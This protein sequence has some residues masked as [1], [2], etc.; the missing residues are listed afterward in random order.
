MGCLI[1]TNSI[2]IKLAA[3]RMEN[4]FLPPSNNNNTTPNTSSDGGWKL[5]LPPLST[6]G[7]INKHVSDKKRGAITP[8]QN[9]YH[10]KQGIV[11]VSIK[12]TNNNHLIISFTIFK[13]V[14]F[15]GLYLKIL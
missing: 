15:L 3:G 10:R 12:T 9:S 1:Y 6:P 13:V 2:V 14:K 5:Y 4:T 11:I 8:L 7:A